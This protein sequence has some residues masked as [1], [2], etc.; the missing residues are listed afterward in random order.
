[1]TGVLVIGR[2]GQVARALAEA[3]AGPC[4]GREAVD[5]ER[6]ET[7]APAIRTHA[8][9]LVINAA[10]Y[11]AVDKAEEETG[12]AT[13][14]NATAVGALAE[15]CAQAGAGLV[16]LSTDYVYPGTKTGPHTEDDPTDPVNAYGASKLAGERA[17]LAAN[18]RTAILRTA[19]VYSPWGKNFVLTMLRLADR[20]RLTVVADQHGQPTSALD[21]ARAIM[22]AAPRLLDAPPG[23]PVWGVHHLAG[24]GATTW[25]DFAEAVFDEAIATGLI[26]RRP[27]VARIT[28]A[29]Y[30]TPARRPANSTLDCSRFETA[31]GHPMRPWPDALREVVARIAADRAAA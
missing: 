2:T 28:T 4:L 7:I 14:V 25:A 19:W 31:F 15:A 13:L 18:P 21:M 12:L 23:D 26:G 5:L 24:A 22:A 20:D 29:E 8:P 11:T 6:P 10:A 3:G 1:M 16:H 27:E 9:R 30:P 17:A